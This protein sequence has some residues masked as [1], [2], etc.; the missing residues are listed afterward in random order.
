MSE[1]LARVSRV[2]SRAL[3]DEEEDEAV[4]CEVT[5]PQRREDAA[6]IDDLA[7]DMNVDPRAA[8]PHFARVSF[9]QRRSRFPNKSLSLSLS[10]S[11]PFALSLS[12]V[13]RKGVCVCAS[14]RRARRPDPRAARRAAGVVSFF[15]SF[16]RSQ[17]RG[18]TFAGGQGGGGRGGGLR[19]GE[20]AQIRGTAARDVPL[21][22]MFS[23]GP[24]YLL[25]PKGPPLA[26]ERSARSLSLGTLCE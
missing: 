23:F 4:E 3:G 22:A 1:T 5:E 8:R 16:F 7:F 12:Q 9:S 21:F 24:T 6:A 2:R 11:P 19:R 15:L 25:F 14:G 18:T 20:A 17:K 13:S 26:F 10:L